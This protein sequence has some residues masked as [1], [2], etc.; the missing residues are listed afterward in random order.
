MRG[1]TRRRLEDKPPYL[2]PGTRQPGAGRAGCPGCVKTLPIFPTQKND[3]QSFVLTRRKH[4][5][6]M[7]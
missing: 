7:I 2:V 6:Q 3:A 1:D 4:V 5:L